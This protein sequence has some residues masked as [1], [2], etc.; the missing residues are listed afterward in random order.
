MDD[1]SRQASE[2][3]A[4]GPRRRRPGS[5]RRFRWTGCARRL[6]VRCGSDR[7][8]L[9]EVQAEA[10]RRSR[11]STGATAPGPSPARPCA[12]GRRC[13][14]GGHRR[15]RAHR[16]TRGLRQRR[17]SEDARR[18]RPRAARPGL[19][20]RAVYGSTRRR[21]AL[22]HVVDRFLLQ[23][24]PPR[25]RAALRIGAY[26]LLEMGTPAHAA[27]SATVS[28]TPKRFRGMVNAAPRSPR[29]PP[30]ASRTR[31]RRSS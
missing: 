1:V 30:T 17:A 7:I 18:G 11:R 23:D 31:R 26:Q 10:S 22:D 12:D 28:A 21:R 8:E 16:R 2:G 6:R 19:R 3:P 5:D 25:A 27:V 13:P 4:D 24:P 20:H 9:V 15:D 14:P 29:Q